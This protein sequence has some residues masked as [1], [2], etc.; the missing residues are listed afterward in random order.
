MEGI[1][2]KIALVTGGSRN[3][4]AEMALGLAEAGATVA[5]TARELARAQKGADELKEKTGYEFIP[6]QLELTDEDSVYNI[7]N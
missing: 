3:F 6:Y 7:V 1:A 2:G 4:G 5:I